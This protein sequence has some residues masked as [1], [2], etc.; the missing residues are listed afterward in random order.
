MPIGHSP[1]IWHTEL[2]YIAFPRSIRLQMISSRDVYKIVGDAKL[3]RRTW[4]FVPTEYPNR[5]AIHNPNCS[6]KTPNK[7]TMLLQ[8]E[9]HHYYF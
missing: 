4:L 5:S 8:N 2:G 7:T 3:H 6:N 1:C 9:R